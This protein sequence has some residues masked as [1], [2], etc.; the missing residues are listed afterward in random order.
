M[1]LDQGH[2]KGLLFVGSAVA[3]AGFL[4]FQYKRRHN[5]EVKRHTQNTGTGS[6]RT[7]PHTMGAGGPYRSTVVPGLPQ[8]YLN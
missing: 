2:I 7:F 5:E 8:S 4:Y 6:V 3:F 1:G